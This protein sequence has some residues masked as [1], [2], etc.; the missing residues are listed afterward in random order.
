MGGRRCL[1]SYPAKMLLRTPKTFCGSTPCLRA[2]TASRP[3]GGAQPVDEAAA[4]L[5]D[6]VVVGDRAAGGHDRL[7]HVLLQLGE[8]LVAVLDAL[9]EQPVGEVD[10]DPGVVHL[11][12][13]R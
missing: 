5:A 12:H 2:R 13:P 9:V 3:P 8:A 11:R 7:P 1:P 10:A 4:Q 6:A